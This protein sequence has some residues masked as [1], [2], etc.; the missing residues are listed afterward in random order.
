MDRDASVSSFSGRISRR[1]SHHAATA[2]TTTAAP[3]AEE[4]DLPDILVEHGLRLV[5]AVI[6]LHDQPHDLLAAELEHGE[7]DHAGHQ[8]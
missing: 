2:P 6:P 7:N 3:A 1:T 5:G 4:H 8:Q